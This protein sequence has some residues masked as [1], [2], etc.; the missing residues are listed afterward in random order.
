MQASME[1]GIALGAEGRIALHSAGEALGFYYKLGMRSG[2]LDDALDRAIDVELQQAA[3]EQR[4]PRTILEEDD[5]ALMYLP[6]EAIAQWQCTIQE[7]PVFR[8]L[9][10]Q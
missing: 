3:L 1:R 8:R 7:R 6:Q 2:Y 9:H 5:A 10:R 4:S